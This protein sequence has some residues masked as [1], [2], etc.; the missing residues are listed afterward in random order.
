MGIGARWLTN[1]ICVLISTMRVCS[2]HIVAQVVGAG[3]PVRR[4]ILELSSLDTVGDG[5]GV[6]V[7]VET[8]TGCVLGAC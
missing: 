8:S 4:E 7:V 2:S 3:V 1:A 5:G 6:T